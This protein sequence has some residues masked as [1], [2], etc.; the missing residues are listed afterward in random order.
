VDPGSADRVEHRRCV[1]GRRVSSRRGGKT[2]QG[3]GGDRP[4]D[5]D[6]TGEPSSGALEKDS[7]EAAGGDLR[8]DSCEEGRD[9]QAERTHEDAGNSNGTGSVDT[10][11][12]DSDLRSAVQRVELRISTGAPPKTARRYHAV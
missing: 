9:T 2:Q 4:D 10:A 12:A 8:P 11:D 3:S 1:P 5:D 7:S 6:G